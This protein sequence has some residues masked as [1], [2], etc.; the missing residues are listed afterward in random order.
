MDSPGLM[1]MWIALTAMGF[2]FISVFSV[3]FS[4]YKLKGVLKDI[5]SIV[6]EEKIVKHHRMNYHKT[7][8]CN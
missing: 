1:K 4:R 3:Y 6:H 2:M 7:E 8:K 5:Y